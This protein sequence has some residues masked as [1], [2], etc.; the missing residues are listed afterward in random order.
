MKRKNKSRQQSRS[1]NST[2]GKKIN[3]DRGTEGRS[4][5]VRKS[6]LSLVAVVVASLACGGLGRQTIESR[7]PGERERGWQVHMHVCDVLMCSIKD[8]MG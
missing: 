3:G 4:P 5:F 8:V 2:S 6:E 7:E 1:P